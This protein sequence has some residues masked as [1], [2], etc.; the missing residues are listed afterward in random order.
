[1]KILIRAGHFFVVFSF[2]FILAQAQEPFSLNPASIQNNKISINNA[3]NWS[4]SLGAGVSMS[5]KNNETNLFRGNGMFNKMSGCYY[6]GALGL[7]ASTGML[8]GSLN[9]NAINQFITERGFS[10]DDVKLT[11]GNPLNGFLLFGPS[12]RFGK[13]LYVNADLQGGLFLNNSGTLDMATKDNNRTVYRFDNGGKSISPGFSGSVRINYPLSRTTQFFVNADYLQSK[14]SINL[15]DLKGGYDVATRLNR[16]VKMLATG[17]G[18]VK[19]FGGSEMRKHPGNGKYNPIS[20][21]PSNINSCIPVTITRSNPDGSIE[22]MTY[23]TP[24]DAGFIARQSLRNPPAESYNPWEMDDAVEGTVLSSLFESGMNLNSMN[25]MPSRLSMTPTTAKQTQGNTFGEKVASGLQAGAGI[26]SGSIYWQPNNQP[27]IV[28]NEMAAQGI[29]G[30]A[31]PGGMTSSSYAAGK[32]A[33]DGGTSTLQFANAMLYVRDADKGLATGRR[34]FSQVYNEFAN[35][36]CDNCGLKVTGTKEMPNISQQPQATVKNPLYEGNTN[37]GSNPMY[38]ASKLNHN[39]PLYQGGSTPENPL[40]NGNKIGNGGG[41]C[42]TTGHF[43]VGL[44]DASN[45][46]LIARTTADSCG[47]FWFANVPAGEYAVYV[48]GYAIAGKAYE[49]NINKDGKMDVGGIVQPGNAQLMVSLQTQMNDSGAQNSIVVVRGWDASAK[50]EVTGSNQ[51]VAGQPIGGIIV[52]GGRNP[53]G[54]MKTV[55]TDGNGQFEFSGWEKGNYA[56]SL[57]IPFTIDQKAMVSVGSGQAH[58]GDPHE[59]L[60]G[61][62]MKGWDGSVKGGSKADMIVQFSVGS[63]GNLTGKLATQDD[64]AARSNKSY[65]IIG[66]DGTFSGRLEAQNFNTCRSNRERGQFKTNPDADNN[67][68]TNIMDQ[69]QFS[70]KPDGSVSGKQ[71]LKNASAASGI[72]LLNIMGDGTISGIL[73]AQDFNTCRSNRDNRLAARPGQPTTDGSTMQ[74]QQINKSK[75]NVK[76]NFIADSPIDQP[77]TDAPTT[78]TYNNKPGQPIGGIIVKG[79]RNPGG[80]MMTLATNDNGEFSLDAKEAGTYSFEISYPPTNQ[81]GIQE[82]GIKRTEAVALRLRDG[83]K[84]IVTGTGGNARA[85]IKPRHETAKNSISNVRLATNSGDD[86]TVVEDGGFL[87]E[88]T[89]PGHY[90][91]QATTP[92]PAG[93]GIQ[94]AGIKR[95]EAQNF[96]TTRSNR[97][98]GQLNTNPD[99]DNNNGTNVM[100]QIQFSISP[101]GSVSGKLVSQK[102]ASA[103]G[104]SLLNIMNDGTIAGITQGQDFNTCRSNRERGMGFTTQTQGDGGTNVMGQIQFSISADGSVSGKLVSQKDASASGKSLLNIMNDGT[105]AGIAQ[106][107]DFNTCRSNRD[108]R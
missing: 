45:G 106:A 12:F 90:V 73:Y 18:I 107:Q 89:E 3:G 53:G 59:N 35:S 15:L 87:V 96:N 41:L 77:T 26:I 99:S 6:F 101:D 17:I 76:N 19:T 74:N 104:K 65:L 103:S 28:T 10:R 16:D 56:I 80:Q 20:M 82:A 8:T 98:R 32:M 102:D 78:G 51:R 84:G 67:G 4:F 86:I 75:S 52:K 7:S 21:G 14:S 68:G 55:Q 23:S 71:V 44:Y 58:W 108:N 72:S 11:K 25:S 70:V 95:A 94:E 33:N 46:M 5:L 38:E 83:G 62:Q 2:S 30:M 40:F 66:E 47:N 50:K 1:M 48:K 27:G 54:Q 63:D 34:Q 97:E 36:S 57:E 42:G 9:E 92:E 13:K 61:K 29:G 43:L 85:V 69:Y 64:I 39:N 91:I 105:I 31:K 88:I 24:N 60:N 49:V 22:Q 100:G 79:G 93:K 81:K 37:S